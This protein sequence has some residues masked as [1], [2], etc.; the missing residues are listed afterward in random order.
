M[1]E[2]QTG[3]TGKKLL[4][5]LGDPAVHS[6]SGCHGGQRNEEAIGQTNRH[7]AVSQHHGRLGLAGAGHI[8]QQ[9]DLGF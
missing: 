3:I 7:Q 2:H 5:D 1:G 4:V 8:L 9:I 6:I